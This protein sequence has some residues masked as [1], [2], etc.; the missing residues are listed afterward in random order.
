[1][2]KDIHAI[3]RLSVVILLSQTWLGGLCLPPLWVFS[4]VSL[5]GWNSALRIIA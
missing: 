1:M 5:R 4:G 2:S 3:A